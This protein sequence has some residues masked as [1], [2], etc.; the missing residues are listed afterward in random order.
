MPRLHVAFVAPS[1]RIVGGQAVQADRLVRAWRGDPDVDA[2]LV[3]VNPIPPGPLRHATKIKYLRTVVTESVYFPQLVAAMMRADVAHIFAASY[4]SFLLAPLP[5]M[6]AARALHRPIVL[7]YRSGHAPKHLAKSAI[8]R[9]AI[10][11]ADLNILPSAFLVQ[12]FSG[13]GI[14]A[15]SIPNLVDSHRFEYRERPR[16]EPRLLSTRNFEGLYNVACTLRAFRLIQ[17]RYP[18][19]SLTL[20]GGGPDEPALRAL[21]SELNLRN[22]RFVGRVQPTEIADYYA[23]HDIYVQSPNV[24]NMPPSILEAFASGLRVVSREAGG[25]PTILTSGVHG[26]LAPLDD[27]QG[28]AAHVLH[29]LDHPD[30]ALQFTRA[31]LATIGRCS[32]TAVR[33]QWLAAYRSV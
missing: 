16:V 11:A 12:V 23:S 31:A 32:W 14:S 7:N 6:I 29:L 4:S 26:L 20:V 18:N 28:L 17:D 1:L 19:A 33:D 10:A 25:I 2:W 3:P 13:F 27:H 5:A 24:D 22:T 8:A 9:R 15:R 30:Q 21:A